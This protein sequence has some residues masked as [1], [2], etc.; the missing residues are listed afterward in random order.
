MFKE[1]VDGRTDGRTLRHDNSPTGL[2]PVEL[3]TFTGVQKEFAFKG[4]RFLNYYMLPQQPEFGMDFNSIKMLIEV[5]G[6]NIPVKFEENLPR[7]SG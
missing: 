6:K 7:G 2:R 5:T 3:K 4:F 1:K